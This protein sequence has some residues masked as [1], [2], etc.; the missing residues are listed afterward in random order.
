MH[1]QFSLCLAQ[2]SSFSLCTATVYSP[3]Q[4]RN[5]LELNTELN[6]VLVLQCFNVHIE[7]CVVP[8]K[9]L[10]PPQG[11]LQEKRQNFLQETMNQNCIF[12]R[13][14][15]QFLEQ[16]IEKACKFTLMFVNEVQNWKLNNILLQ[17]GNF[18]RNVQIW[19]YPNSCK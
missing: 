14:I 6:Y 1:H 15:S 8:E 5:E 19:L 17:T 11:V 7:H 4:L 2:S 9:Y 16:H 18:W 12:Q 3:I 13:A 10:Y